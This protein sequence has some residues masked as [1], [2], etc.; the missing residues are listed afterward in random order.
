[1]F[2]APAAGQAPADLEADAWVPAAEVLLDLVNASGQVFS[3]VSYM[4]VSA[5]RGRDT[6]RETDA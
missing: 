3:G 2:Y 6:L 4:C 1:M 5:L